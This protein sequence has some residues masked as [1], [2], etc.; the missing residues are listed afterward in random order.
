MSLHRSTNWRLLL[1]LGVL[2]IA[3]C[4]ALPFFV[5]TTSEE[6]MAE[7]D[8]RYPDALRAAK[9]LLRLKPDNQRAQEIHEEAKAK[10]ESIESFFADAREFLDKKEFD[11][12]TGGILS[13]DLTF[14]YGHS[15][16]L[17]FDITEKVSIGVR[18]EHLSG[19]QRYLDLGGDGIGVGAHHDGVQRTAQCIG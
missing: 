5:T 3:G 18:G 8:D 19:D 7:P 15:L 13:S 2:V 4:S 11:E 9:E 12:A 10:V 16:A 6:S 17:I 1:P 14:R